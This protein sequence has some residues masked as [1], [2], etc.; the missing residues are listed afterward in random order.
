MIQDST[1]TPPDAGEL[2]C[3]ECGGKGKEVKPI[4][5]QSLLTDEAKARLSRADGFRFCLTSTCE[6]AYFHPET[7]ERFRL[8]DVRVRIGRKETEAPRPVCYCFDHTREEIEADVAQSG[9]SKIPEMI[10]DKCER[11]LSRC[12]E[13]NPQG[14]C[15]LGDVRNI[16]KEA[17]GGH[18]GQPLEPVSQGT[19]ACCAVEAPSDETQAGSTRSP[20]SWAAGGAVV[21]AGLS[22]ACCWVPLLLVV[23]GVS[24]GG[25]SGFFEAYRVYLLGATGLLLGAGF[26]FAYFRKEQCGPG[27]ACAAPKSRLRRLNRVMIWVATAVVLLFAFFPNYADYLLAGSEDTGAASG[28]PLS[29]SRLYGIEGMTCEACAVGI[30]ARLR[31]VP[32]IARAE[33][34]YEAGAASIFFDP[35]AAAPTDRQIRQAI[36]EAGYRTSP[37][38]IEKGDSEMEKA[39]LQ[40]IGKA[41]AG[42]LKGA[43]ATQQPE[44]PGLLLRLLAE[45]S[46]VSPARVAAELNIAPDAASSALEQSTA[47]ELDKDGNVTAAFGLTLSPTPHRFQTNGHEFHTWCAL[48]TL[49]IP[50]VIGQTARV[51]STCPVTGTKIRLTV[52]P[53]GIEALEPAD[54]VMV[55]AIPETPQACH[56]IRESF[57]NHVHFLASREAVSEWSAKNQRTIVLSID[58]AHKVGQIMLGYL[59]E[60]TSDV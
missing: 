20:R 30:E 5:V 15:C 17:Q 34:S 24:A 44:L 33:V 14:S 13:S 32:G 21:A 28:A 9:A 35:T 49:Y 36:E 12:E 56:G 7:G 40:E 31:K 54:A 50:G 48:D 39:K 55:I 29:E 2:S 3:P 18:A 45:G 37:T 26:H 59:F 53:D 51:E 8:V 58:D 19:E 10:R 22:S 4:T 47:V 41:V 46:P 57:C 27:S 6:V 38:D 43:A 23:F 25:V 11:G 52:T 16:L 60:Q 1:A 42:M